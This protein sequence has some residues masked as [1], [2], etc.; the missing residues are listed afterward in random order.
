MMRLNSNTIACFAALL[1]LALML[2]GHTAVAKE[3]T[4][5]PPGSTPRAASTAV[6]IKPVDFT[7]E[8]QPILAKRCYACHGP[9]VVEGGLSFVDR[10]LALAETDSGEHA[11]VPGEVQSS[12]LIAR[13]TSEDANERMPPEGDAVTPREVD[14]LRRWIAEGASW[15]KHWAFEPMTHPQPPAVADAVWNKNP[16]DAFVRHRLDEAGLA[17]NAAADRR[18]LIRRAYYDLIGLPPSADEVEQILA[19]ASP[20]AFARLVN[21]LLEMPQYGERWGRHWLDLVRYAESNSFER[22]NPKPNVWKYRDY[23]IRSFNENKPYDQ[24]VR[25]QLAGDELDDVTTDTLTA[26]GY[27]RLGIWDDEPADPLQARYDELD[28]VIATTGQV[29]LGLTINCA[30]CHDHKIDPIPQKDYYSLVAFMA[31]LTPYAD[32]GDQTTANQIDISPAELNQQ[33]ERLDAQQ[34]SLEFERDEIENAGIVKMSAEDQR[35]TEGRRNEREKVL[36]RNLEK[37][38]DAEQWARYVQVKAEL[39]QVEKQR[40][41]LPVRESVLGLARYQKVEPTHVMYRGNPH[42]PTDEVGPAFPTLFGE[43]APVLDH[44]ETSRGSAGRRRVLAQWMTEADNRLAARVMVNRVWQY[45]FGRGLVRSSNNFGQL[46]TPPTHPQLLDWLAEH[47]VSSGWDLKQLHRLIMSSRTY[48]MSSTNT[49]DGLASDPGNDLLWRF[50]PRRLSAEEVRDSVLATNGSINKAVYGPS[51]YP[52]L[53]AEVLAGQSRPGAGWGDSS[54]TEA[55]RRSVYI[56]VKRSLITPLLEAF[57]FPEPDRSCEARFATLQ[58]GQALSLL[59]SDFIHQ[60]AKRLADSIGANEITDTE[61]ATRA[62]PAVLAREA[63]DTEISDAGALIAE[64]QH[65]YG[66]DRSRAVQLYCLTILNWN[67]FLFVD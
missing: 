66:M 46:G 64:L 30:R 7:R 52:K 26:T 58:P 57:D 65:K 4:G 28:D 19:D 35:A 21:R 40:G 8:V 17:P 50:D 56:H 61:V 53:S 44:A 10:E 48:Q 15:K 63:T 13:I 67:E 6:P 3:L 12:V 51:F 18:T 38:L 5:T 54:E 45:H 59:N 62:I 60:Q 2:G 20:D 16:I 25:E 55:N 43:E 31:D 34:K 42:S 9:D 14:V 39:A 49:P 32:R 41:A 22:D 47:F 1:S 33:Y 29:F 37:H 27:Y 23:V 24:F 36:K 11:I